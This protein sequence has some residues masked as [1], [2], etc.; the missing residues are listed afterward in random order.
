MKRV[1]IA[2]IDTLLFE[3]VMMF[4][5]GASRSRYDYVGNFYRKEDQ[6]NSAL[7]YVLLC[8]ATEKL[9]GEIKIGINGKPYLEEMNCHISIS[10]TNKLVSI[11]IS[12]ENI[13]IDC[14]MESN[15]NDVI[16]NEVFSISEKTQVMKNDFLKVVFWTAKEA[17]S[18]LYNE[19]WYSSPSTELIY[20]ANGELKDAVSSEVYLHQYSFRKG[21]ICVA[22][23]SPDQPSFQLVTEKEISEFLD[24]FAKFFSK[25]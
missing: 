17:I 2:P 13:G 21:C 19:D 1:L 23:V 9:V 10:H 14:E 5:R 6:Y 15:I 12:N 8:L 3:E 16:V 11:G 7:A 25:N 18:K 24:N 4:V 20:N 22:S